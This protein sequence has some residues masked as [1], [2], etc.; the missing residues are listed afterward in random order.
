MKTIID[1]S[2]NLTQSIRNY[3]YTTYVIPE[4][5]ITNAFFTIRLHKISICMIEYTGIYIYIFNNLFTR[6]TYPT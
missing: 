2:I 6:A 3:K 1:H 4:I 5:Q